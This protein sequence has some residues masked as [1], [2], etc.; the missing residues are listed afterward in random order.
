MVLR[1]L[2]VPRLQNLSP[3]LSDILKRL[4]SHYVDDL[5]D[6]VAALFGVVNS[7]THFDTLS[8]RRAKSQ[9]IN[10]KPQVDR[11]IILLPH[12][13]VHQCSVFV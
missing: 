6:C 12:C 2:E 5:T 7:L 9:A 13:N 8:Y 1:G 11:L 3:L 10:S 4:V